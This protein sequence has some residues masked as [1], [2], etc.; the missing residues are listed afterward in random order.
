MFKLTQPGYE[1]TNATNPMRLTPEPKPKNPHDGSSVLFWRACLYSEHKNNTHWQSTSGFV[2]RILHWL[3]PLTLKQPC[4]VSTSV[5]YFLEMNKLRH[6]EVKELAW[7]QNLNSGGQA[8]TSIAMALG[9]EVY[10]SDL[11]GRIFAGMTHTWPELRVAS[12][13]P[14]PIPCSAARDCLNDRYSLFIV[15]LVPEISHTL[16]EES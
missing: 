14:S 16:R 13:A 8:L 12:L 3:I 5:F 11:Q 9:R 7:G 15:I 4:E 2:L 10:I 6:E 1:R